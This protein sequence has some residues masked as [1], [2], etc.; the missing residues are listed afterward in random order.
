[1]SQDQTSG[2][3]ADKWGRQTARAI[4]ENIGAEMVSRGSNECIYEG[5][6]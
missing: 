6:R 1:M 5:K 2:A 3:V 4:A